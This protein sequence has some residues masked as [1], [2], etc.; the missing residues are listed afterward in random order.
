MRTT[1]NVYVLNEENDK[2]CLG[3]LDESWLWRRR[4]WHLNFDH[5]V[6]LN[7]KQA[8][9]DSPKISKPTNIVCE[10]CQ[11]GKQVQVSFKTKDHSSTGSLQ[12]LQELMHRAEN[13][14]LCW[15]LMII[16]SWLGLYLWKRNLKL[17]KISKSSKP[18][19]KTKLIAN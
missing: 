2:C 11:I 15:L 9:R 5:I 16:P 1:S 13:D 19:M 6:K 18:F 17:L 3:K 12:D 14:I 8:I 7:N 4:L 10:S